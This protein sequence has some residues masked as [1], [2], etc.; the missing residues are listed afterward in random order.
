VTLLTS[1]MELAGDALDVHIRE[2][3]SRCFAPAPANR[4]NNGERLCRIA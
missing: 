2:F 4:V 1:A 3:A